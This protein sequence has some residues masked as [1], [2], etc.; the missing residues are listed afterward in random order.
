MKKFITF[1]TALICSVVLYA[2]PSPTEKVLEAFKKTFEQAKDV[3]WSE[4]NE[5]YEASFK[6]NNIPCRVVYDADGNVLRS[7]RYYKG[8]GLPIL[9]QGKL[10]S[11][12]S[13][14]TVFGVTEVSTP[15]EVVY[16]IVLEDKG[17]FYNVQSDSFGNIQ[18][19][20]K[21]TK[22]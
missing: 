11:K 9:I 10:T 16:H 18:M 8:D 15:S 7:I 21:F 4:F 17:N 6:Q 5:R 12:H 2:A 13:S 19:G 22:S 20:K 3:N 1:A 14:Q